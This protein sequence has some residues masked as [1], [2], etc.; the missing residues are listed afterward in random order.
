MNDFFSSGIYGIWYCDV[1]YHCVY[2]SLPLGQ[3][4]K[5][6]YRK[7]YEPEIR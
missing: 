7:H 4:Y 3:I 1:L 2:I 6:K 5:I